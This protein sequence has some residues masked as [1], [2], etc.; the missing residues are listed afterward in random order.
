MEK[1]KS[2]NEFIN[3]TFLE[4]PADAE[5]LDHNKKKMKKNGYTEV[6]V[7]EPVEGLKKGDKV[8][9]SA[10]EF[11]QLDPESFV[12]CYKDDKEII[13]QKKNLQVNE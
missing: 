4:N 8:L 2:F 1:V 5:L 10:M 7:I 6:T 9:V 13:T 11:G 12:T 3:E